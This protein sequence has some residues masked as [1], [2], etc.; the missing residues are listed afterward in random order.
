MIDKQKSVPACPAGSWTMLIFRS[1]LHPNDH[2][3]PFTCLYGIG[4]SSRTRRVQDELVCEPWRSRYGRS[5]STVCN[6]SPA[7]GGRYDTLSLFQAHTTIAHTV[8]ERCDSQGTRRYDVCPGQLLW[9]RTLTFGCYVAMRGA[10]VD[11]E[12]CSFC[13]P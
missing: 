6:R 13:P 1:F 10:R 8:Q 3:P 5:S 11:N 12:Q 2:W 7:R 4:N 9:V